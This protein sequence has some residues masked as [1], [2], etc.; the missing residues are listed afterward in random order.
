M[1]IVDKAYLDAET[2]QWLADRKDYY[3]SQVNKLID[4]EDVT[5]QLIDADGNKTKHL[6]LN[7]DTLEVLG[8]LLD[9]MNKLAK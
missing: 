4:L 5:I 8:N 2:K 1:T 7:K 3:Q 9:K 6:S